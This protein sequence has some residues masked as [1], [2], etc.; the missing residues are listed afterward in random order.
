[1]SK[2]PSKKIPNEFNRGLNF[3]T[4]INIPFAQAIPNVPVIDKEHC[5]HFKTG[6]CGICAKVCPS[7]A[8]D[9]EIKDEIIEE[10][11]GAIVVATGFDQID[12]HKFGELGYGVSKDVVSS[13]EY[14]RIMSAT[15]PTGGHIL[16]PSDGKE[17]K[18]VVFIQCVGSRCEPDD[19]RGKTYCSKI[20]CMYTAKQSIMTCD[21]IPDAKC[22]VFYIDVRTPGKAFDE[23]Y[24]RA[25]E[26]YGVDYIKGNVGKVTQLPN[27]KLRVHG[28]DLLDQKEIELDTDM[29]VLA[30]AIEPNPG[31]RPLATKLTLSIDNNNFL[32]EAHAKLHPVE[33]ATAGVFMAGTV[34][35]PR[36]IPE[37]VAQ[38]GAAAVKAVALLS[39]DKLKTNPC[40]AQPDELYCNGCSVC[41]NVC[42]YGAITYIEKEVRDHGLR[43]TRRLA[44]VNPSLCKGCGACSVACPSGAMNL[45]GFTN[46]Q[47][48]AEVDSVCQ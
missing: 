19:K 24:R 5:I 1:M 16:R 25:V 39:K 38:A 42:P 17:P 40:V 30:G 13:L 47:I 33:A 3:R 2:C 12:L 11:Y 8:V 26:Q 34:Q 23:F 28:V 45:K 48:M 10:K 46:R 35:G 20:C 4:A 43:E 27:G 15:G 18:D 31:I 7:H 9:Y 6:K 32:N 41:A 36:D 44:Q 14:E 22:H 37:T 29:V 21:H